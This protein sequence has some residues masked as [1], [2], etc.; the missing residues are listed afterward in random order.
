MKHITLSILF[1][2]LLFLSNV[3]A[4][5][6]IRGNIADPQG[7]PISFA[8]VVLYATQ[9]GSIKKVESSQD[10]GTFE[11]RSIPQGNYY[12]MVYFLAYDDLRSA[13]FELNQDLDIGTLELQSSSIDL[14]TVVVKSRRT[15]VEVKSDRMVFN[16]EGT[17]NS[18]GEDALEL[19]RKA[20]GVMV[21]N[22]D[23]ISVLSRSGVMIYIDGRRLPLAGDDLTAY[24]QSIPA[25]QI[26]RMDIITNPGAKYEAQGNAGIIDI[27]LKKNENQGTNG[28]I[29]SAVS[30]GRFWQQN[31]NFSANYRNKSMNVFGNIG[32]KQ[33][34]RIHDM[35]W[36]NEQFDLFMDETND[37]KNTS[38][39]MNYRLGS[40]FYIAKNH[41]IGFL[42]TGDNNPNDR[43]TENIIKISQKSTPQRID[44][45]LVAG[46]TAEGTRSNQAYNLNYV[47]DNKK[48]SINLDLDFGRYLNDATFY[49]PN[50]YYNAERNTLLSSNEVSY[51]TPVNIDIYTAKIDYETKV[52]GGNLGLG[53][54]L[55]KV[56]THNTYLF[57]D[58]L[59]E[60]RI[61]DDYLSNI[62]EY[63]E[64]VY[65][66][67]LSYNKKLS[68]QWTYRAGLRVEATDSKGD[69]QTFVPELQEDPVIQN[70]VNYF[71]SAGLT[72]SPKPNKTWS[73]NYGR[74]INRPNYQVLNPFRI[75]QSELSFR[76][77]NPF[78]NPETVHNLELGLTL[79][80][81]FNFKLSYSNTTGQI[82]RLISPDKDDPR[83]GYLTWANL[84]VQYNYGFNLSAPFSI[85]E[86]WN[87]F[88]NASAAYLD[89]QADYG[90]GAIVD[91][92]AFT[93][94][95]FQQHTFKLPSGFTG[96][97]SGYYSGPGIWGGVFE[98]GP[99]WTLNL[100]LQKKFF[101]DKLLAKI[102]A[103]DLFFT[104]GWYGESNFDGLKGTGS[105]VWDSRRVGLSLSY[106]FGNNKIKTRKRKTGL[107]D[108]S[109]RVGG[110]DGR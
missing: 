8:D 41:T 60:M 43:I 27:R 74:R 81:R 99:T 109:K 103:K 36:T 95:V 89:N 110:G 35:I 19:L 31:H 98:Y 51:D 68:D 40:D 29:S 88:L 24:L 55:S 7:E 94:N 17:I 42:V 77:G 47:F 107:E 6:T 5:Y 33:G 30:K 93:Y 69:L 104:T 67:Y 32:Y 86:W 62:F 75:Q 18:A 91:V 37:F 20:P 71:P 46:S 21:D 3:S 100:G 101:K 72:F 23:N 78:L 22:N 34:T 66:A 65:A 25:E 97:V 76:Q 102:S 56:K 85:F 82:T 44:S 63:D 9:D 53:S 50:L 92:Q 13:D 52:A 1:G 28:S 26:D 108:E 49:Q 79:N 4:Q 87:V 73:L 2:M 61:R 83:A 106:T 84:A 10:D 58:V 70:Y 54:K 64:N 59:G 38:G 57:Y 11:M 96:E 90:N 80:Y 15:I 39:G 12:I 16:V 105:G 45:I 48:H 14:E